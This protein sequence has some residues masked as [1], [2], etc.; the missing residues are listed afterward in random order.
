MSTPFFL[1]WPY[2]FLLLF[3]VEMLPA[4]VIKTSQRQKQSV[5]KM[6]AIQIHFFRD[7]YAKL[8]ASCCSICHSKD[9]LLTSE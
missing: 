5:T 9:I 1:S 7:L 6:I 3:V 8:G 4:Y 2:L